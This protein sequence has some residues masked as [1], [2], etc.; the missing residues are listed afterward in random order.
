MSSVPAPS[1]RPSRAPALSGIADL[2]TRYDAWLCDV[3]GVLHDGVRPFAPAVAAMQVHRRAG[4]IVLLITNAPRP[5]P[6]IIAQ[7]DQIG[8]PRDAY[9]RVVTSGDSMRSLL[10]ERPGV[11]VY[12]LGP[13]RDRPLLE[14]LP[15]RLVGPEEAELVLCSGLVNDETETPDDYAGLLEMLRARDLAMYCANPDKV[16]QRGGELV[17]CAGALAERYGALGGEVIMTGKPHAPIYDEAFAQLRDVA[18]TPVPRERVLAIGDGMETDLTGAARQGL[19]T[20][21]ITGGIH[22]EEIGAAHDEGSDARARMLARVHEVIPELKLA[23]T[24]P[25]LM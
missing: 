16:V 13:E 22:A 18:G 12:H 23:G 10:R 11:A 3:W 5:A 6:A 17:F 25:A 15:I 14:D 1:A 9:D 8:V 2:E 20:V 7:L 24:M 19:D 4:G 21:F